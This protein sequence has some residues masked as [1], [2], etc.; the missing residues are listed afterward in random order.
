MP[1]VVGIDNSAIKRITCHNCASIIEYT[2][3]EI[4][5][6]KHSYDYTGDYET[7]YGFACPKCF[8]YIFPSKR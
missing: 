6:I 2:N 5:A 8:N 7:G 1:I 3:S 4:K